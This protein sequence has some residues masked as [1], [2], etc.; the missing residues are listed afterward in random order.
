MKPAFIPTEPRKSLHR[1]VPPS[2]RSPVLFPSS[3]PGCS[4]FLPNRTQL[5][6][7]SKSPGAG[8]ALILSLWAAARGGLGDGCSHRAG[9]NTK[10]ALR[11]RVPRGGWRGRIFS[12]EEANQWALRVQN[13]PFS[14][15]S[16][17]IC[18]PKPCQR[19]S[20]NAPEHLVTASPSVLE[21]GNSAHRPGPH[22]CNSS[23]SH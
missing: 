15:P 1:S 10:E 5:F 14:S 21:A 4:M 9:M 20:C 13:E 22:G 18:M 3:E 23:P 16:L 2:P 19:A 7:G 8:I 17:D 6:P 11:H 12:L